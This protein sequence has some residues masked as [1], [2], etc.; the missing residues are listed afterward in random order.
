MAH[1]FTSGEKIPSS[2]FSL[3]QS[4]ELNKVSYREGA[5]ND[6]TSPDTA[7]DD[8]LKSGINFEQIEER[9]LKA[10]VENTAGNL[11]A[12]ARNI[13]LTRPQLAYRLEKL[14]ISES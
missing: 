6:G 2:L 1:L 7:I 5:K 9:F 3:G 4:G 13:G 12:A 10:A 11:S 8:L 14:N